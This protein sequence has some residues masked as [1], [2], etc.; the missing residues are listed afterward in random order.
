M[1]VTFALSNI[2]KAIDRLIQA[3]QQLLAS[4]YIKPP[5]A[6]KTKASARKGTG[7]NLSEDGRARIAEAQRR[8]WAAAKKAQKKAGR[9][10]A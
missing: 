10:G 1:S 2:D 6:T 9:L 7:Y 4:P 3:R 5:K 8:R